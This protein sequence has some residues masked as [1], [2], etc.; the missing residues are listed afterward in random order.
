[1][2]QSL[3]AVVSSLNIEDSRSDKCVGKELEDEQT[4]YR[5][6]LKSWQSHGQTKLL[7]SL[8]KVIALVSSL[9]RLSPDSAQVHVR[10][11][12]MHLLIYLGL[13]LLF[14]ISYV[15]RPLSWAKPACCRGK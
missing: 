9:V 3:L 6:K 1:V 13:N 5:W 4:A 11:H 7:N 10:S 15:T 14:A 2:S 12:N 8:E